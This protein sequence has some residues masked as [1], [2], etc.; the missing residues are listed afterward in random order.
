M[1]IVT[2]KKLLNQS[3][4]QTQTSEQYQTVADLSKR[5]LVNLLSAYYRFRVTGPS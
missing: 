4:R 1:Y 3:N 2:A 5:W